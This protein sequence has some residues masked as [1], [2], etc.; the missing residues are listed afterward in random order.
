MAEAVHVERDGHEAIVRLDRPPANAITLAV[1]RELE[2]TFE[3]LEADAAAR[4]I[5]ITGT[6][7]AF[8]GGLDLKVVPTYGPEEQRAMLAGVNRLLARVYGFPRP[9][10]AA[11]N[12]HAV[13]AGLVIVLACDYRVGTTAPA[14]LGL[15][16]ARVGIPFPQAAADVVLA[17]LAPAVVRRLVLGASNVDPGTAL[18]WDVLDELQPPERVVARALEVARERAAFPASGFSRV[19]RQARAT[20]LA[21]IRRAAAGDDPLAGAWLT[22]ETASAAASVLPGRGGG[23]R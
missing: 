9:I 7:A 4:A 6:G 23:P 5:V 20:A 16:E 1:L 11:V 21:A 14:K 12:G 8:S 17:E 13:A 19:K 10:V 22:A 2:D 18:A 15:T 3:R